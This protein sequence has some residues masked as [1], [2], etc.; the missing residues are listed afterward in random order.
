MKAYANNETIHCLL[1][2]GLTKPATDRNV[3]FCRNK[4]INNMCCDELVNGIM[5]GNYLM[6]D[7]YV[8]TEKYTILELNILWI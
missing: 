5:E 2:C 7:D 4:Y 3:E 1:Y 6:L 8:G